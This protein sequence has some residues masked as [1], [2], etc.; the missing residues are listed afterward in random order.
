MTGWRFDPAR[1]VD[2]VLKP[3]QDGWR[4]DENL[5]RVYL[6]PLDADDTHVITTALEEVGRQFTKQQYRAFRRA[7]EILR[8]QHKEASATLLDPARRDSHRAVVRA[9]HGRLAAA[10]RQRL[11][12]APGLPPAEVT[13]LART[14]K[15]SRTAILAVLR[16]VGGR[17]QAPAELPDTPEPGRWAEVR[18]YLVQ[19]RHDS[20]W[21]YLSGLGGV[22][23][24]QLHLSERR[25]KLRV[26]RSADS[27]AET[28]L[29]RLVQQWIETG[30][31][32]AALRHELL[33]RLTDQ[34]AYG[35]A[36]AVKA[37]RAARHLKAVG[38]DL[39]PDAVAFA[40]WCAHQFTATERQP[41]WQ[42]HYQR[43]VHDLRLR[44]AL[45]VLKQQPALP[46]EWSGHLAALEL[47]LSTLD[48]ELERCRALEATDVEAAVAG[49]RKVREELF[50][51]K[52]DTALERCRPAAPAGATAEVRDGRVVVSWPPSTA[53]A[54]RIS[55]RVSRGNTVV[56]EDI[57]VLEFADDHVPTG[58]PLVYSIH[59]L[60]DGNPSAGAARTNTVVVLGEVLDLEARGEPDAISGRWRLPGGAIGAQVTRS[61]GTLREVHSTTFTDHD[62]EPGRA[63][64]YHVRAKYRLPDG[65]AALSTGL[66]VTASCQEVPRGVTDL[67]GAFDGDELVVRW[68]PPPRG[69]VELLELRAGEEPPDPDVVSVAR[70]RRRGTPLRV[71]G[72][73]GRGELRGRTGSQGKRLTLVP[74]TILG[75]LAAIGRSCEV[76][77]RHSSV[78]G[79]RADR[80]G[81]TVRLTW[82]WPAG[83]S[84]AR[85]VWR[86]SVRPTAP[87]DP[88]S[89]CEDVTRV[90]YDGAGV[91]ISVPEG[92]YWF[93]VCTSSSTNGVLG[94]GPMVLCRQST[95]GTARYTVR[96]AGI[97]RRRR[98][99]VVEGEQ[100]VPSVVL[101]AKS[102]VRPMNQD[103]GEQLL[104]LDGGTSVL[105]AEFEVPAHLRRPVHLRAFSQD[106]RVV[107]V[108]SRPDQLIV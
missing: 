71:I 100:D 11:G 37:A 69:D 48:A 42:E 23:T 73:I 9:S 74:V 44:A 106:E 72:F 14:L 63:Y 41:S 81:S 3:V 16:E 87:T 65:T 64:D 91:S 33:S 61:G 57:T 49:Y 95:T 38:L 76:D 27:A 101:V 52:I 25:E 86:K 12:G 6:L 68:T 40:V 34:A 1:F 19:L 99:L 56:G 22:A 43:A 62:V 58:T 85:V 7:T 8:G 83:V 84:A 30:G 102:G 77:A 13:A 75:E 20:L 24:T 18:G 93:G 66:H 36:E 80:L 108:P 90:A 88:E 5:F 67:T 51:E 60:R 94:F 103:D 46:G 4:P 96:R 10:V 47:R 59:A 79:L 105:E 17:E 104:R 55:Y 2:E 15:V 35:Y 92:D 70:A 89:S 29:L 78:R 97:R 82:E 31:L 98:T 107:L 26:S 50:D 39:D 54:G 45:T 28:T 32:T 21:D 53:T